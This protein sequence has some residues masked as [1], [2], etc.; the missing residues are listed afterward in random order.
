MSQ[1]TYRFERPAGLEI[2]RK[3]K[4][5]AAVIVACRGGQGKLDLLMASLAAQ[6]YPK[7]LISVMVVLNVVPC[8]RYK[9]E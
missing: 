8:S 7:E 2:V 3:P 6:S 5:T 1:P 9:L 4:L